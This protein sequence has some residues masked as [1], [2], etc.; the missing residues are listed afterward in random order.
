MTFSIGSGSRDSCPG[1]VVRCCTH[2]F[3]KLS[4]NHSNNIVSESHV[5]CDRTSVATATNQLATLYTRLLQSQRWTAIFLCF[6]DKIERR[7][8][9]KRRDALGCMSLKKGRLMDEEDG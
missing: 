1:F 9:G 4:L 7:G 6:T 8:R 5:T 3:S 2:H